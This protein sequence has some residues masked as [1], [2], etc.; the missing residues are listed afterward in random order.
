[1]W[2]YLLL[3]GIATLYFM[4][5]KKKARVAGGVFVT[6]CDS[7]MGKEVAE[8]AAA[9]GFSPVFAGCF[10]KEGQRRSSWSHPAI[11]PVALDVTSDESVAQA[12]K[13]V[14]ATLKKDGGKLIGLI[15]CAGIPVVAPAEYLTQDLLQRQLYGVRAHG[16][17]AAAGDSRGRHRRPPWPPHVHVVRWISGSV[18]ADACRLHGIQVGW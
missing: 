14:R 3:I 10:T 18:A 7:G 17:V 1:M 16:D 11:H 8:A 15:Q 4:R 12:V 13:T 6:G 9:A 2:F 5:T